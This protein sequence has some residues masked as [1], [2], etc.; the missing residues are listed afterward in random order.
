M[1]Q[2][3]AEVSE[4]PVVPTT[5]KPNENKTQPAAG[6]KKSTPPT[7]ITEPQPAIPQ[8]EKP[9][10][11]PLKEEREQLQREKEE[12]LKARQEFEA[13]KATQQQTIPSTNPAPEPKLP[14]FY[15]PPKHHFQTPKKENRVFILKGGNLRG[16]HTILAVEDVIDPA[17]KM[18]RRARLIRGATSIWMDEQK[19]FDQIAGYVGK[20]Q[21][22]LVFQRGRLSVGVNDKLM[23]EFIDV[24]GRNLD[25]PLRDTQKV[26]KEYFYEW[27]TESQAKNLMEIEELE[28]KA[29]GI[30]HTADINSL[31]PHAQ[32]LGVDF[33]DST[34][35]HPLDEQGIRR[36]YV[37]KA[38]ANPKN[39]LDSINSPVVQT[40]HKVRKA[41]AN[42]DIDL[43]RQPH[44]AYWKNGGFITV[45]PQGREAV[46]YLTEFAQIQGEPNNQF[47]FQLNALPS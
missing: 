7:A 4:K 13:A 38:K 17:T 6:E 16:D 2:T 3:A 27:N 21:L 36:A 23:N 25:N 45:I 47:V 41:L 19:Q 14:P 28:F 35:G 15:E 22:S 32:Y 10:P 24:S 44:T 37:Q 20:N 39:F 8:G 11:D 30:A 1:T 42:G 40:S 26:M 34:S 43:G 31:I 18:P 33:I 9:S 29:V 46:A 12:L 5:G